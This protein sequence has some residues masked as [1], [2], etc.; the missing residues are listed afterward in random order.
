MHISRL[1]DWQ[2]LSEKAD[3]Y[4]LKCIWSSFEVLNP[5][6]ALPS[7]ELIRIIDEIIQQI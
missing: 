1:N 2:K 5:A 6:A 7:I 3:N 4:Q